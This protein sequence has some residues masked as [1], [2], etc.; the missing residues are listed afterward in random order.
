MGHHEVFVQKYTD[1]TKP[2]CCVICRLACVVGWYCRQR[3]CQRWQMANKRPTFA[4][5]LPSQGSLYAR[6]TLLGAEF[7]AEHDGQS[8]RI[9]TCTFLGANSPKCNFTK[10]WPGPR[11]KQGITTPR[12]RKTPK[13]HPIGVTTPLWHIKRQLRTKK[14]RAPNVDS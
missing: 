1:V 2:L 12:A 11:K 5:S 4:I 13:Q 3:C 14:K 7:R 10:F 6:E 8:T 9:R